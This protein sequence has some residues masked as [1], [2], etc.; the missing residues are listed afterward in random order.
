MCRKIS[1]ASPA[2]CR[3]TACMLRPKAASSAAMYS[4]STSRL[5][6]SAPAIAGRMRS[7]SS[8]PFRTACEPFARPSP[9]SFSCCRISSRDCF[10]AID[11]SMRK[12]S[13]SASAATPAAAPGDVAPRR[14][15]RRTSA[16]TVCSSF[17]LLRGR[18]I[19]RRLRFIAHGGRACDFRGRARRCATPLRRDAS[20][21]R[22]IHPSARRGGFPRVRGRPARF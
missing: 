5:A 18:A 19:D 11:R 1:A 6:T 9:S 17:W 7:G 4:R 3:T 22:S 12:A 20:S 13:F 14:A 15:T 8:R 16:S 2:S 21:C 10:S